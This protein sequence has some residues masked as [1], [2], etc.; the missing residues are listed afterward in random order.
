MLSL[1]RYSRDFLDTYL[2]SFKWDEAT[3]VVPD[4]VTKTTAQNFLL[5]RCPC[6]PEDCVLRMSE[7]S[8]KVLLREDPQVQLVSKHLITIWLEEWIKKNNIDMAR[9]PG[10]V[11]TLISYLGEFMPILNNEESSEQVLD[12]LK[13]NPE[14]FL[15][16][17]F[18]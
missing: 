14:A 2:K 16:W 13:V 5:E 6:L 18:W 12:W 17:G 10:S 7:W 4:L 15:R 9:H 1:P 8:S 3:L 11:K